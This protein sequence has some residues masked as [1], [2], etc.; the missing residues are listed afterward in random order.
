M[1]K[2]HTHARIDTHTQQTNKHTHTRGRAAWSRSVPR[3]HH[4]DRSHG[5]WFM[6]IRRRRKTETTY[7]RRLSLILPQPSPFHRESGFQRIVSERFP[8]ATLFTS[9]LDIVFGRGGSAG[10]VK[11]DRFR[12]SCSVCLCVALVL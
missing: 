2:E 5:L 3:T 11:E 10:E 7:S 9:C 6:L 12:Y 1:Q 8:K 4:S